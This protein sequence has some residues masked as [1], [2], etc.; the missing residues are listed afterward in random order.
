MTGQMMQKT[1]VSTAAAVHVN[2]AHL[3]CRSALCVHP[4]HSLLSCTPGRR[5]E[6]L[7]LTHG[8]KVKP[9]HDGP[10]LPG[11]HQLVP[12]LRQRMDL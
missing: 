2:C 7:A 8:C 6:V 10:V 12:A 1:A 9:E 3:Q 5:E 11:V 4:M